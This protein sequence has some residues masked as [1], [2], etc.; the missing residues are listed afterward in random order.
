[1][2]EG[3]SRGRRSEVLRVVKLLN[4]ASDLPGPNPR[5]PPWF[6]LIGQSGH[7]VVTVP[8]EILPELVESRKVLHWDRILH[9]GRVL[10]V[11]R[12]EPSA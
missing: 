2:R 11:K 10:R 1:M 3:V 5:I 7:G 9:F 6:A 8:Q 4:D 12:N